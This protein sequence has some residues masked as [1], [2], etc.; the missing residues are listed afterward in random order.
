MTSW[1]APYRIV[2]PSTIIATDANGKEI[3]PPKAAEK[4][5]ERAVKMIPGEVVLLYTGIKELFAPADN[6]PDPTSDVMLVWV[7][8]I[9]GFLATLAIRIWGSKR[10]GQPI[11][12]AQWF[13][14]VVSAATFAAW[15]ITMGDPVL[16]FASVDARIGA[17]ILLVVGVLPPIFY[18]GSDQ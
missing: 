11:W 12:D 2:K 14:V 8:P 5:A 6:A 13:V 1:E 16:W 9:A 4:V 15:V 18:E 17:A 3:K 10:K 7:L